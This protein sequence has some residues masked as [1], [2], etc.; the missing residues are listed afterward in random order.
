M[1]REP[2]GAHG[3]LWSCAPGERE[4]KFTFSPLCVRVFSFGVCFAV[5]ASLNSALWSYTPISP[6][7]LDRCGQNS[8]EYCNSYFIGKNGNFFVFSLQQA[9]WNA[10]SSMIDEGYSKQMSEKKT[11]CV[12]LQ[13]ASQQ[14]RTEEA[15]PRELRP[16]WKYLQ[17]FAH[18]SQ[19]DWK[20]AEQDCTIRGNRN[21]AANIT[22]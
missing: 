16:I 15:K 22:L 19:D 3:G 12:F 11:N 18:I 13:L 5:L 20:Q 7:C 2:Q 21:L 17:H 14:S 1:V 6:Q 8:L 4:I 9:T 10:S